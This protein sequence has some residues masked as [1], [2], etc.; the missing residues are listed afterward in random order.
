ML[1]WI[2]ADPSGTVLQATQPIGVFTGST[3][4]RVATQT[5]PSGGGEDAA[6]QQIPPIN[7]LGS[8]YVG[9]AI[10]TRLAIGAP[11]SIPYRLLGVVDGTTLTYD[12]AAPPNAPS[13][14]DAGEI[15][16]FETAGLFVVRSQDAAH[17]FGVTHYMPGAPG[18]AS[19][20]DSCSSQAMFGSGCNLGDEDWVTLLPPAQFLQRYV[21]FTDPTYATTNLVITRVKGPGG[22]ADVTID[23]LGT[24]PVSGWQPVDSAGDYQVAYVDLGARHGPG[25]PVQREP[26]RGEERRQV[27]RQRLGDGLVR[28]VRLPRGR[29]RGVDQPGGRAP[30]PEVKPGPASRGPAVATLAAP[31]S[32]GSRSPRLGA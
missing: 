26:A 19:R 9:P 20:Q 16:E 21:F 23:C 3:Y 10:V 15:V 32:T 31:R 29:E 14:L 6:H 25:G 18:G 13:T 17:P 4:L 2:G 22:F 7:A 27:R 24:S 5:S 1:Q 11:E 30:D 8:E 12:P 28:V